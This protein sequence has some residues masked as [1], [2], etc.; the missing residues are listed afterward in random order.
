MALRLLIRV[1]QHS[2]EGIAP[3]SDLGSGAGKRQRFFLE[4]MK[5]ANA[6]ADV[7][8]TI[9]ASPDRSAVGRPWFLAHV[10]GTNLQHA[11]AELRQRNRIQAVL[12]EFRRAAV[13]KN[14]K[15]AA[16][17][18]NEHDAVE[19]Y[20]RIVH[21]DGRQEFNRPYLGIKACADQSVVDKPVADRNM[22]RGFRANEV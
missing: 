16:G 13:G 9:S 1:S 14:Q 20:L 2:V 15:V 18:T 4:H 10:G 22:A 17:I 7:D 12:I 11:D 19:R 5:N 8:V 21:R 6:I 3:V